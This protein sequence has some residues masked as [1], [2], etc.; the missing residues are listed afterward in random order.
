MFCTAFLNTSCTVFNSCST[1][2]WKNRAVAAEAVIQ[3]VEED[4]PDYVMDVLCEG[5]EWTEWV[6]SK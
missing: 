1:S 2:Y 6:E 4:I 5:D 3:Q